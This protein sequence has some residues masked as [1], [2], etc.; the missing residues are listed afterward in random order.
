M[1][2]LSEEEL[3]ALAEGTAREV[4]TVESDEPTVA[5]TSRRTINIDR[6]AL[7]RAREKVARRTSGGATKCFF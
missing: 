7:D 6:R 3:A 5:G 4:P 1:K 2:P